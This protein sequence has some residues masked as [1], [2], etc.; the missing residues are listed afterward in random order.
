MVDH[1][2]KVFG[3]IGRRIRLHV[4]Q[5]LQGVDL[6]AD[7]LGEE[8]LAAS[9]TEFALRVISVLGEVIVIRIV[10]FGAFIIILYEFR[11]L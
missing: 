3:L 9:L 10:Y 11:Q 5:V 8:L 2:V 1:V 7:V 4:F 6:G